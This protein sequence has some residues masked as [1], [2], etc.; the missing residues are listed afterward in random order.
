MKKLSTHDLD[1]GDVVSSILTSI[2]EN[3]L[4]QRIEPEWTGTAT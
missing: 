1:K 4:K 2:A 3:P